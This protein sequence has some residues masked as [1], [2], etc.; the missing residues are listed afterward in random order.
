MG[1]GHQSLECGELEYEVRVGEL[2]EQIVEQ[3]AAVLVRVEAIVDVGLEAR[4]DV[5][6]VEF[7]VQDEED[8]VCGG[9]QTIFKTYRSPYAPSLT[10]G[11][12]ISASGHSDRA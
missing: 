4:V 5:A 8:G 7:A 1:R 3:L 10:R 2:T 11:A 9:C 6:V 12:M